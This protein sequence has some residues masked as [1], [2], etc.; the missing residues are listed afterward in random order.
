MQ[1]TPGVPDLRRRA[2]TTC[3]SSSRALH[4]TTCTSAP[5]SPARLRERT[6]FWRRCS[7]LPRCSRRS[8]ALVRVPRA[9]DIRT[10][11]LGTTASTSARRLRGRR[12][13]H[14]GP[15][16]GGPVLEHKQLRYRRS[17]D[18]RQQMKL[19]RPDR[20][21]LA[22]HPQGLRAAGRLRD[23]EERR[24]RWIP[25][26]VLANI[27]DSGLRGRGGAGFRMARRRASSHRRHGEIPLCNADEFR[28][29]YVQ[30]PRVDA[31]EPPHADRGI[32]IATGRPG[33]IAPST[34]SAAS[35]PTADILGRPMQRRS[36][37]ATSRHIAGSRH[38]LKLVLHRGAGAY[39]CGE[40]TGLLDSLE[41]SAATHG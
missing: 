36:R 5:T 2:S 13:D 39:I 38:F 7:P 1:L 41:A 12:P 9:C 3:L 25:N 4:T 35:T 14:R 8:R 31:E 10:D 18:G 28:A 40:E 30:G 21:S 17:A 16:Q 11:G 23:A 24:C 22:Q 33:S 20:T 19:C 26:E 6:I 37:R 34:T 32:V 15:A 27:S 29:G